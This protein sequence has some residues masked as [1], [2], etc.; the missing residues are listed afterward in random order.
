MFRMRRRTPDLLPRH[1]FPYDDP[2]RLVERRFTEK[3]LGQTESLFSVANGYLG[4][5]G[6]HDEGR[7]AHEHSTLVAGFHET[8]PIAHAEEAFGLAQTGQTIVDVPDTKLIQLYVDDEPLFL[9]TAP[10]SDYERVLDFRE[11]TLSRR[12]IWE[13]PSG[14]RVEI[15]SRRLTSLRQRHL[16]AYEYEVRMLNGSAP[17]VITSQ[18][19]N[20]DDEE[21]VAPGNIDPRVRHV[22]KALRNVL[23]RAEGERLLFGYRT[24]NSR[25][26]LGCGVDHVMETDNDYQVHSE[27]S[28]DVGEVTYIVEAQP[29]VPIRLIKYAAYHTSRSVAPA[30]LVG[31]AARV[32]WR[33]VSGG[34]EDLIASQR[35]VLDDFWE[36]SDVEVEGDKQVQQAVRW[37][38]FQLFQATARAEGTGVPAK[39]LTGPGYEGHYFWD[40]ETFVLPF[41]C[42]TEPRTAKNL[43]HFRHGM[44]GTARARASEL[45]LAGALFPWRT[46]AGEEAS[47]YYQAGTAQYHLDADIAY[48][49]K[50]YIDVTGDRRTLLKE[51]VDLLVG[52]A[53]MWADLGHYDAEGKFHL[54]TVTGPDEYTTVVNDNAFTNLMARLNLNYA[55]T[56][57]EEL[58]DTDV[59]RYGQLCHDVG[60]DDGETAEWRRAAEMMH[61]PYDEQRGINPQDAQFLEREVWDFDST[62]EENYP[63]LLHYHPLVIYRHQVIKQA[64]VVLAMFLLGNE[65]GLEQ[66]RRNFDYYDPL[67]TSDSSLSPPVHSIVAAEVGEAQ[68]A[69]R[70]FR[71]ALFMDLADVAQNTDQGVHIA[72]TGGVWMAL[73]YGFGGLRDHDGEISFDPRLPEEWGRLRFKLRVRDRRLDIAITHE[74]ISIALLDGED[75][76]IQ[77]R[78]KGVELGAGQSIE[79]EM[80]GDD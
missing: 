75:L 19:R 60:I 6:N 56:V 14:K 72:S 13:T 73:V 22:G 34:F 41:L 78:G 20:H 46:I 5:R 45:N 71:L 15:R 76:A 35:A 11:G 47:A 66:K 58:R 61:V 25:M 77:V 31:R 43:L 23:H 62:P 42:Y 37:N 57:I 36:R 44:L 7:P 32:L 24:T 48:A 55:A 80:S 68:H 16:A 51:G 59:D 64:D 53:R 79:V 67:T 69:M 54:F 63:L 28:E 65:F 70:H 33:A 50:R 17:V 8:W 40:I 52:T 4:L 2:W 26:T 38:L 10:T 9:P 30:E 12:L 29:D 3:R 18:L 1:D 74:C 21:R 39:G 27:C 49:L